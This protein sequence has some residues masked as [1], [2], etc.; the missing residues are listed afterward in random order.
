[1]CLLWG[2]NW[3]IISQKTAFF[4]SSYGWIFEQEL[5][6]V[7]TLVSIFAWCVICRFASLVDLGF[8]SNMLWILAKLFPPRSAGVI[9]HKLDSYFSC[10]CLNNHHIEKL[11]QTQLCIWMGE[12]ICRRAGFEKSSVWSWDY[13]GLTWSSGRSVGI[14]RLRTKGRGVC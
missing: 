2:T 4:T 11:V 7:C 6:T 10:V 14:V 3:V 1:M 9:L 13:I 5:E 12:F 8:L